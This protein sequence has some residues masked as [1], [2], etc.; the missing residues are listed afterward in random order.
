MVAV[1]RLGRAKGGDASLATGGAFGDI[2][3]VAGGDLRSGEK[4]EVFLNELC[5]FSL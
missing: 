1:P 4:L 5:F 2:W 3:L